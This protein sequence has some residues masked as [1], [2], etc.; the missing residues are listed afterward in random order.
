MAICGPCVKSELPFDI[1]NHALPAMSVMLKGSL[2]DL[3]YLFQ[4][5]KMQIMCNEG[6]SEMQLKHNFPSF[7]LEHFKGRRDHTTA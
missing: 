1:R 2:P 6:F 5:I 4:I 3:F 7:N